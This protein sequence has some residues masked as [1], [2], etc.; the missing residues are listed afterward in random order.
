MVIRQPGFLGGGRTKIIDIWTN[1]VQT[2][3]MLY[4]QHESLSVVLSSNDQ[5]IPSKYQEITGGRM[6]VEKVDFR[7]ICLEYRTRL[8]LE[9]LVKT[10]WTFLLS[11]NRSI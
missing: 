8:L 4:Q 10:Q 7:K 3:Y 5:Y 1:K 6:S 2:L 9:K 11:Q